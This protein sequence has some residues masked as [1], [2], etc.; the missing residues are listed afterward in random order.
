MPITRED[1]LNVEDI[2][3]LSEEILREKTAPKKT[4]AVGTEVIHIFQ[5]LYDKIR[6]IVFIGDIFY[7]NTLNFF[8]KAKRI[9]FTIAQL[10]PKQTV[11]TLFRMLK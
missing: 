10:T 2:F 11:D 6:E 1:V 5:E 8:T 9:M 4:D 3:G 7:V